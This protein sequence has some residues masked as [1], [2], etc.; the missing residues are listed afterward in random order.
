MFQ[1]GGW[2]MGA[3]VNAFFKNSNAFLHSSSKLKVTS[4]FS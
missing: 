1:S 2:M 4:F 3:E